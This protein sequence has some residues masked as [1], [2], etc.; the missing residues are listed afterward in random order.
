MYEKGKTS[1][2]W[3]AWVK[4]G[5]ELSQLSIQFCADH[6]TGGPVA[7]FV[8]RD[9]WA[10]MPLVLSHKKNAS[11]GLLPTFFD[12]MERSSAVHWSGMLYM[13]RKKTYFQ[14]TINESAGRS[15]KFLVAIYDKTFTT[16]LAH[17]YLIKYQESSPIIKNLN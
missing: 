1:A 3:R 16:T 6:D 17:C 10:C 12:G 13:G 9:S 5:H 15:N 11:L 4:L 14:H 2:F 8:H 7:A